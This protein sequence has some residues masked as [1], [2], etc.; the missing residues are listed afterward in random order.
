MK[1]M[2]KSL[3]FFAI[4]MVITAAFITA[5]CGNDTTPGTTAQSAATPTAT[6]AGGSYDTEQTVTLATVTAGADIYYTLDES[7]PTAASTKYV[8]GIPVYKTTT[9]KAIA[10]KTGM[11][12]S[13]VLTEI[14]TITP[15]DLP[16]SGI[17][18]LKAETWANGIINSSEDEQWFKFSAT[19]ATQYIHF[20]PGTLNNVYVQVY[21]DSGIGAGSRVNL[22]DSNLSTS[23]TLTNGG[24]YYIKVTPSSG[25]G[26]Y[27]IAFN[28]ALFPPDT[29]VTPLTATIWTNTITATSGQQWFKF[30]ATAA[31]QYIHV[32][33]N[34]TNTSVNVQLYDSNDAA[35]GS[36]SLLSGSAAYTS[37]T[38]TEGDEYYIKTSSSGSGTYRI[39]YNT[40]N[41]GITTLTANTWANSTIGES[42]EQWFKFTAT[43]ATQ[44]IH[45]APGSLDN[46]NVQLYT[47]AIATSG[48]EAHL[49]D[50]T[51]YISRS[52]TISSVYYI[53]V[54][55]YDSNGSGAFKIAFNTATT[56]PPS[57]LPS[58]VPTLTANTWADGSIA[59]GGEQWFNFTATATPQ[60]IHFE[61]GAL[62]NVWVQLYDSNGTIVGTRTNLPV[63]IT[64]TLYL[65]QAVT[66]NS[67]YYIKVMPYSGSGAYRIAFNTSTTPPNVA[68][69][70]DATE[71]TPNTWAD[72]GV[73]E[74][75]V[76]WFKFTATATTQYIHFEEGALSSAYVQLYNN[77]GAIVGNRVKLSNS[78]SYKEYTGITSNN[79]YYI[80]VKPY[81]SN[82]SGEYRIAFSG[83]TEVV[84]R[85]DLPD[86]GVTELSVNTWSTNGS[87]AAS[88]GEQWFKFTATAITQYIHFEKGTLN[89][90][91]VQ[92]YDSTGST[93]GS[94]GNLY[95]NTL[96][97]ARTLVIDNVY[98]IKV[99]PNGGS[100]AYKIAFSAMPFPPDG[101][102]V[103]T[104]TANVWTNGSI[105]IG[106][107]E[108][109]Q[110]FKFT[111]NAATQYIYFEKGTLNDVYVQLYDSTGTTVGT[112]ENLY[113]STLFMNRS[114]TTSSVYYIHV[115]PF[116]SGSGAYR[117]AFDATQLTA[118]TWANGNIA[119]SGAE[120]WFKF[121]A[122]AATQYI[123]FEKGTLNNVYVQLYDSSGTTVGTKTN[124]YNNTLSMNRA[125]TNN[126]VYYIQVTPYGSGSGAYKIAFSAMPFPPDGANVT[127]LTANVWA[128]GTIG[129]G[130]GEQWFKFTATAATQYIHFEK[131]TLSDVFVQL[132]TSTGTTVGSLANLY[133]NTLSMNRP[134]TTNSVYY[135]QVR[136]YDSGGAYKIA[137]NTTTSLPGEMTQFRFGDFSVDGTI[138]G[139]NISVT[140]PN[141]VNLTTLAP[142]ITHNGKSVSPA[143]GVEQDF[144]TS[145]T[146]TVTAENNSTKNYTV[147]VT[148]TSTTLAAAFSWINNYYT[149][150]RT[151]T[152]VAKASESLAPVTINAVSNNNIILSGGTTEKTISLSS[153]GS[154]FRVDG[155]TLTLEN[156]ITLAG[157]TANNASLVTLNSSSGKLVMKTGSKI[158]NNTK[159]IDATGTNYVV[160]GGG[161]S[162]NGGTFTMDG[163]TITG[164]KVEAT[165]SSS[166]NYTNTIQAVGGGV[167]FSSGTFV[168]NDGTISNNTAYS[169][170]YAT[171]GGGVYVDD[172]ETFT[173]NGGTISGNTAESSSVLATSNTYGGGVAVWD[174]GTFT[175]TGG[176]ISGNTVKTASN[177][178]GG[179]VYVRGTK[180]TKTG[181]TIYGSN[182]SPTD[183]R[184]TA[185][186]D[187]S[188]H[189]VYVYI[190]ASSNYKRTNTAGTTVNLNSGTSGSGGGWE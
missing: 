72:G 46:V 54:T 29:I 174:S 35:V 164:N 125:V 140:V 91:Y 177:C 1:N 62:N 97:M 136:P 86:T 76:Q 39:M 12:N 170:K 137:F 151:Y 3:R 187:A 57:T 50:S 106:S 190:S 133:N 22:Y 160:S 145:K 77:T 102:N 71:L 182:A 23:L 67:I 180:F 7:D 159:T 96:S 34:G 161:V 110:W 24:E 2:R 153:N 44:Y 52:I 15:I 90:V 122:T 185:K 33:I 53:K 13:E 18:P 139:T 28:A 115:T 131:G 124:L 95:N 58:G 61:D 167:F 108:R 84:P 162:I 142:T 120:Q 158:Q 8:N 83:T 144:T 109:E 37:Q 69:P 64:D 150:G 56:P 146:Y 141:I 43:A 175:M 32:D 92:L 178:Y 82:G 138:S 155:G 85:I 66:N 166:V 63:P 143:S 173:M 36:N 176:T 128:N 189:A 89:N 45:F 107:G 4:F 93:T 11:T 132:Y 31:T 16:E 179:G 9:L 184:N 149:S 17:T 88:S 116:G 19:A 87:I 59:E 104:L 99:M 94:R 134:V 101:A 10:V 171:A 105:A 80:K 79:V 74:G 98:H 183:L 38:L 168:M 70:S 156:N 100:G 14:Y 65:S 68:P 30:T 148:V 119:A 41:V 157:R 165:N 75:G 51:L 111:A 25:T 40:S 118:N 186:N 169:S 73:A 181:G 121:T 20:D 188:G 48:A 129:T 126:N 26:G 6:P 152:I 113:S 147:T 172:S 27:K 127:Q 112:K 42:E 78:P 49:Y 21:D 55:P 103:T 130:G 114:V 123:H 5:A 154:L 117:I 60:Y 47:S 81:D 163:G 135:I